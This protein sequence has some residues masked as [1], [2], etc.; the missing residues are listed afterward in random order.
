LP[1]IEQQKRLAEVVKTGIAAVELVREAVTQEIEVIDA[2]LG[3]LLRRAF[4]GEL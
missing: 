1:P 2:L 4:S 3:V